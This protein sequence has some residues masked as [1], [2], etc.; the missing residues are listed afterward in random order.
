VETTTAFLV[1]A[2]TF[3]E[4]LSDA[5]VATARIDAHGLLREANE[6][7]ARLV[8]VSR[9]KLDGKRFDEILA[10]EDA[11]RLFRPLRKLRRTGGSVSKE[12][13]LLHQTGERIR[14]FQTFIAQPGSAD[15][16]ILVHGLDF[17]AAREEA[18]REL[19]TAVRSALEDRVRELEAVNAELTGYNH[20]VA[21]DMRGPITAVAGLSEVLLRRKQASQET[22]RVATSIREAADHAT[23]VLE[24]LSRLNGVRRAAIQRQEVDVSRL[25]R[26][27]VKRLRAQFPGRRIET[28]IE[29]NLVAKADPD[30]ARILIENLV[31]NAWKFTGN[32]RLGRINFFGREKDGRTY[33]VLSDNGIGF[34][35]RHAQGLFTP[36]KRLHTDG[37]FEGT[38]IGLATSKEIVRRHSGDIFAEARPGEGAEF[39]FTLSRW[40]GWST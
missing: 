17:F 34:D 35:P 38:G 37:R 36:F 33:F 5:R 20:S 40:Q 16:T 24:G 4:I 14:A 15:I 27:T 31:S 7:F 23:R 13:R 30:L 11:E 22:R 28:R 1:P 39:W 21:H 10:P 32:R 25:V 3:S 26:E 8:G 6:Q 19:E 18:A 12:A 9:A 29:K 2:T